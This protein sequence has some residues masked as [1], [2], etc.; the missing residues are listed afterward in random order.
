[1]DPETKKRRIEFLIIIVVIAFLIGLTSLES[2]IYHVS[3]KVPISK[4]ALV[5]SFINLNIVLIALLLFL[6][7]RNT[8]KIIF[9][10]KQAFGRLKVRTKLALAFVFF[11]I[12]PTIVMFIISSGFITHTINSWFSNQIEGSL[13][14][15]LEIAKT[16]YENVAQ[17]TISS[18]AA[19]GSGI[20][21]KGILSPETRPELKEFV[22]R[23]MEEYNLT[24]MEIYNED[25]GLL[26]LVKKQDV[27]FK[28]TDK[29]MVEAAL[30]GG[31]KTYIESIGASD[32]IKG[33]APVYIKGLPQP[34]GLVV[35]NYFIQKSLVEKMAEIQQG[36]NEYRQQQILKPHLKTS[37]ILFL[38]LISLLMIFSSIWLSVYLAKGI[39]VQLDG[40]VSATRKIVAN[41]YDVSIEKKSED[42]VGDLV[43]AFNIMT[44]ELK[45][46]R[47]SLN[48]AYIEQAQRKAYI[49]AILNSI[50]AG[51]MAIDENGYITMINAASARMLNIDQSSAVDKYYHDIM[52]GDIILPAE[53]MIKDMRRI[54]ATTNTKE[55]NVNTQGQS[56]IFILRLTTLKGSAKKLGGYIVVFEDVTDLIKMQRITTWQEVA[57]R[58]AHEIKNPLTPI[59][60]SAERLRRKYLEVIPSDREVFDECTRTIVTEVDELRRLVD[61]FSSFARMPVS[62]PK[63]NSINDLL[64]EVYTLYAAAHRDIE[65][66]LEKDGH[67]PPIKFD[68]AQIRRVVINLIENAVWAVDGAGTIALKSGYDPPQ[69]V[70]R[71]EVSDTGVGIDDVDKSK[72]FDLYYS[73][74]KS[75]SGL[76]LAIVQRI[77]TE[78][79]GKIKVEDNRPRGARFI[80]EL[81]AVEE[82][83]PLEKNGGKPV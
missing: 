60:L 52:P 57:K 62:Q 72:I 23:K 33:F 43:D 81:P 35:G 2:N 5:F 22:R 67:V 32:M 17:N 25:G 28:A 58:M 83:E 70:V 49:E 14:Q 34:V 63:L 19:I 46:G 51:V 50:S 74:K 21:E 47:E 40:L 18:S 15:S 64:S 10:E 66:L 78:H 12:I 37:Y 7:I 82:R 75:G 29:K 30:H 38:V 4:N 45:Q 24:A 73:K 65:F 61:E 36:Y 59:R 42:E 27:P 79:N 56:K 9:G 6:V 80:I 55:I 69:G 71:I 8:I 68:M 41:D 13:T 53:E 77:I 1:M 76:G 20:V 11:S 54:N 26:A 48:L 39:S 44:K 3:L 31:I 16:Y